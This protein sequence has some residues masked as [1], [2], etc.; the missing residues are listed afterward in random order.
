MEFLRMKRF[1]PTGVHYFPEFSE[2]R[3]MKPVRVSMDLELAKDLDNVRYLKELADRS[4]ALFPVQRLAASGVNGHR[5]D[6]PSRVLL[7][8]TSICN[9]KCRMCPQTNLKRKLMHMDKEKYKSIVD[10]LDLHGIEGLWIH[11]FGESTGHPDFRELVNHVSSKKHLGY[12]WLS[13]NG[14]RMDE[15]MIDFLLM[16]GISFLNF[17]LQSIS[18]EGYKRIAPASPAETILANLHTLIRKKQ[19]GQPKKPY[20]RLQ[21]IEQQNTRNEIDDF[22]RRYYDKCDL[23]SVNMLE[24]T[25]LEF[26]KGGASLRQHSEKK[27]CK[28]LGRSDFIINSDGTTTI[29]DNAYNNQLD[30]GSIWD[31]KVHELWNGRRRKEILDMNRDGSLWSVPLCSECMDYDL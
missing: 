13:T 6:F 14:I 15:P 9:A 17:S 8:M 7:E 18:V 2:L 20:F 11:H 27:L 21:I 25:D 22:L 12:I 19:V 23:I 31:N 3:T 24:H 26:N 28:R 5:E 16:S 10:E 1:I 29:C 4:Y 30:I